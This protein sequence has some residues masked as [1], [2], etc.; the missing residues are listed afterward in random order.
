V[1]E[2][3]KKIIERTANNLTDIMQTLTDSYVTKRTS[4]MGLT[5]QK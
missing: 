4:F 3:V 5:Q 2:N 1:K